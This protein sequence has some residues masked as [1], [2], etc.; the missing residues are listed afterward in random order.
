MTTRQ[1]SPASLPKQESRTLGPGSL[2]SSV[3][4]D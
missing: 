2:E 1:E 4:T 3:K